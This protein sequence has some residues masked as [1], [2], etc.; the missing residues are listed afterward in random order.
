M[1][2]ERSTAE[3]LARCRAL[4]RD[5]GSVLVAYSGGVDSTLLLRLAHEELGERARALIACSATYP[6]QEVEEA[7]RLAQEMGAAVEV[8]Y[9]Q[10]LQDEGFVCNSPQRCYFCKRALFRTVTERAKELGLAQVVEGSNVDDAGDYRPGRRAL[11]EWGV[12]SP[13]EE[14]GLSKAEIRE[15]SKE[16]GL[17]TWS[18]PAYACLAS[19]IPYGERITEGALRRIEQ[20]E[21]FLRELGFVVVRVRSHG[22]LARIEVAPAEVERLAEASVRQAV[23]ARLKEAGFQYVTLDLQGYRTGSMNE[24]LRSDAVA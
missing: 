4:L 13:L 5:L 19:R 11:T 15:L 7:R 6:A 18:K 14:A 17:P 3:K 8:V 24:A 22:M 23:V 21:R 2:V 9:T 20:S 12:R 16:M 1:G 10:E